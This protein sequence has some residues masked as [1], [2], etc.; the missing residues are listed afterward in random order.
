MSIRVT[1]APNYNNYFPSSLP[2]PIAP[3][4]RH[5]TYHKLINK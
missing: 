5:K 1:L 4:I 3:P 2:I